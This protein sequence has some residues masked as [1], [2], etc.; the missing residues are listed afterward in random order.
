MTED[1]PQ[2]LADGLA[3]TRQ[4]RPVLKFGL[5]T[6]L[7]MVAEMAVALAVINRVAALESYALER[8]ALFM[9]WFLILM[10]VPVCRFLRS[11]VRMF[12]S[13]M[14]AWAIFV[15]GYN[16]AGIYFEHLFNALHHWPLEVLVEGAVL[17]GICAVGA[18]VV[19]MIVHACRY[20]IEPD[21]RAARA[22][23][24]HAR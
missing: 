10:L 3:E 15:A 1:A 11:P 4:P 22:A 14:I 2:A 24:R 17:Y 21:R 8:N 6:G 19:E 5:C 23:A 20:S 7:A 13:A 18:W 9:A 12:A 16:L